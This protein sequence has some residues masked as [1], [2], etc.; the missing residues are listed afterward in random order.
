M[1]DNDIK[2][3]D[4]RYIFELKRRLHEDNIYL[5]IGEFTHLKAFLKYLRGF[6]EF[7][8]NLNNK[9][10]LYQI[11]N[12]IDIC[13]ELYN[14]LDNTFDDEGNVKASANSELKEIRSKLSIY[15]NKIY[16]RLKEYIYSSNSKYFIADDIITE[17]YNRYLIMCKPNFRNYIKAVVVDISKSGSTYYVEP[18]D[19]VELNN[20]YRELRIRE[21]EIIRKIIESLNI[22]IKDIYLNIIN[23]LNNYSLIIFYLELGLFLKDHQIVFPEFTERIYFKNVHHP[24]IYLKNQNKSVPI[25]YK[26]DEEIFLSVITGPNAGG[27]TATIKSIGINILIAKTGLPLFGQFAEVVNCSNLLCDIGDKQSITMDLS[28]FTAHLLNLKNVLAFADSKSIV[29][30]DEPGGNTEPRKGSALAISIIRELIRRKSKVIVASHYEDIK[31][32]G[33][34]NE[35]ANI[36]AVSYDYEKNIPKYKLIEG[37]SGES[38]PFIIARN[39]NIPDYIIDSAIK[40]YED[41]YSEREKTLDE[42][43]ELQSVISNKLNLADRYLSEIERFYNMVYKK[44]KDFEYKLC[45]KEESV[46]QEAQLYLLKSK[47]LLKEHKKLKRD[48]VSNNLKVIEKRLEDLKEYHKYPKEISK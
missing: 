25:D 8:K 4:D 30:L 29:L 3:F 31:A 6:K 13:E 17:R 37:I 22:Y 16:G 7:L 43:K 5:G 2:F 12:K 1:K 33:L 36:Y 21:D 45:Q 48:D 35:Y 27:K 15:R 28:S 32:Q 11:N 24:L 41:A 10:H 44:W 14:K 46:L 47:R 39:Y 19:I 23:T 38:S 9:G 26:L 20:Y 18:I 34:L 42:I 40:I